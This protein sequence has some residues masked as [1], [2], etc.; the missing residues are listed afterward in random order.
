M[1]CCKQGL[2]RKSQRGRLTNRSTMKCSVLAMEAEERKKKK[3]RGRF[4]QGL[5][6]KVERVDK[7][8]QPRR[9]SSSG[10]SSVWQAVEEKRKRRQGGLIESVSVQ[11]VGV[12]SFCLERGEEKEGERKKVAKGRSQGGLNTVISSTCTPQNHRRVCWDMCDWWGYSEIT[13]F[14]GWLAP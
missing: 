13:D 3:K 10:G 2:E 5:K 9:I 1:W 11:I 7:S 14:A 6:R 8:G 12:G 4:K